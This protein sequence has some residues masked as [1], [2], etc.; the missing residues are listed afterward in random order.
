MLDVGE[1]CTSAAESFTT[2]NLKK[3][4]KKTMSKAKKRF[5]DEQIRSL[6]TM[7]NSESKLEPPEKLQLARELG[8]EPRQVSIWFQNKRAR[9]KSK[10]L[11]R[12]YNILQ[13]NY[14]TL[15]SQF[16][17]LEK[18]KQSLVIQLQKLKDL[19]EKTREENQCCRKEVEGNR[20]LDS[21]DTKGTVIEVN[22]RV[23]HSLERSEQGFG[24]LS[25]YDSGIKDAHFELD[26]EADLVNMAEPADGSLISPENWGCLHSNGLHD[27]SSTC[28]WWD[29]WA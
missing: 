7:F 6:E 24:V 26:E 14:N 11:K 22:P 10:Q 25:N 16:E 3:L 9:W 12:D 20:K 1:Y 28:Q 18:E 21:G 29:F 13:A 5:C 2:L 15:A 8:L 27:H 23:S 4:S 17:T 19:M